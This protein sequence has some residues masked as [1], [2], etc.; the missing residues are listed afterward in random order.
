ML[1]DVLAD[2]SGVWAWELAMG[3]AGQG[4]VRDKGN[5][6]SKGC[7]ITVYAC[8]RNTGEELLR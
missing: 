2:R 5:V 4:K 6:P 7:S 8:F 1:P 3:G